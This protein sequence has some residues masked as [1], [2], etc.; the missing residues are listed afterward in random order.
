[1]LFGHFGLICFSLSMLLEAFDEGPYR[2][3]RDPDFSQ[4]LRFGIEPRPTN[5][6]CRGDGSLVQYFFKD[7]SL[8]ILYLE[9]FQK[10]IELTH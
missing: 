10:K 7:F 4:A 8:H 3:W 5:S 2:E 1:M 6:Y 9:M